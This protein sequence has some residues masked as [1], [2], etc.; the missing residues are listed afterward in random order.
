MFVLFIIIGFIRFRVF[1]FKIP[2]EVLLLKISIKVKK[3]PNQLAS[4]LYTLYL[5]HVEKIEERK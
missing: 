1:H 5:V 4:I 3:K 2:L